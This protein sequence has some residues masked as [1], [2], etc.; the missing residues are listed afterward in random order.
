MTLFCS[1]LLFFQLTKLFPELWCSL[2]A[3][4]SYLASSFQ[5]REARACL[6]ISVLA[7]FATAFTIVWLMYYCKC[8]DGL[9]LL[10]GW[11]L[12][13]EQWRD[14]TFSPKRVCLA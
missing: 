2:F 5:V 13:E 4:T 10:F 12:Q 9:V 6:F 14:P 7:Y 3:Y 8:L 1:V 11:P